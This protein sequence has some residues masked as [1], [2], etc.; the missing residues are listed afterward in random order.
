LLATVLI[1]SLARSLGQKPSGARG[2]FFAAHKSVVVT[3]A[4]EDEPNTRWD[5]EM[6][7]TDDG[8]R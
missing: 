2:P 5:I 7:L 8:W 6:T 4:V 1:A 3:F